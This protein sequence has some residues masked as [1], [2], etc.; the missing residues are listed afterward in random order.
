MPNSLRVGNPFFLQGSEEGGGG[1][2]FVNN[3]IVCIMQQS[4]QIDNIWSNCSIMGQ[5]LC[6]IF[7]QDSF[8]D[9]NTSLTI[10]CVFHVLVGIYYCFNYVN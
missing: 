9:K 3:C 2:L 10:D 4:L 8:E 7:L 1:G 5:D 6:A